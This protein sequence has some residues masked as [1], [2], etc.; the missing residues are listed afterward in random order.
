VF[1]EVSSLEKQTASCAQLSPDFDLLKFRERVCKR[2]KKPGNRR[3]EYGLMDRLLYEGISAEVLE[4]S[5]NAW[6]D[7]WDEKGWNFCHQT[8]GSWLDG[9]CWKTE[10]PSVG[11]Q[12]KT[13]TQA[14]YKKRMGM[15]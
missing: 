3:Y 12:A 14:E 7:Y 13:E 9:E 1:S 5:I 10:P 2:W 4:S 8:L 6:A 15:E 11:K